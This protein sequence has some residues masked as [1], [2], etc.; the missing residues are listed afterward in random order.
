MFRIVIAD[1]RECREP[2]TCANQLDEVGNTCKCSRAVG[3]N[4]CAVCDYGEA[5]ATCVRCTNSMVLRNG[6]CVDSCNV[7]EV[8]VGTG[9][10]GLECQ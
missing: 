9:T 5:G 3:R 1:G 8:V 4:S 7:G 2:F 10:D 6:A